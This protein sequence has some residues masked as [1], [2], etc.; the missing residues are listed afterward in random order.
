MPQ[1]GGLAEALEMRML[2]LGTEWGRE[3]AAERW[4][5]G[6]CL[7]LSETHAWWDQGMR[8][9]CSHKALTECQPALDFVSEQW[10]A[11]EVFEWGRGG[12]SSRLLV[13]GQWGDTITA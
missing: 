12:L 3:W 4:P 8:L 9:E 1:A 2:W 7:E 10:G 6:G 11:M 13:P 5:G